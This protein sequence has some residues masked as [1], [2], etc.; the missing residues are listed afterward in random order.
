MNLE[1]PR[2]NHR[3]RRAERALVVAAIAGAL[4]F[5][6]AGIVSTNHKPASLVATQPSSP[7]TAPPST[8][9]TVPAVTT[10]TVPATTTTAPPAL[11]GRD[12]LIAI[13]VRPGDLGGMWVDDGPQSSSIDLDTPPAQ[14]G[15]YLG[16]YNSRLDATVR[17][18]I[19]AP[20]NGYEQGGM[21]STVIDSPSAAAVAGELT[22][23]RTSGF[24]PCAEATAEAWLNNHVDQV[25][26]RSASAQLVTLI[27]APNVVTWRALIN[28]AGS[29]VPAQFGMDIS[30]I[31]S[32]PLLA[33]VRVA[34][35][36]CLS[37]TV[38]GGP[39]L[40]NE[41]MALSAVRDRIA[42]PAS[43]LPALAPDVAATLETNSTG[44][45]Q[46]LTTDQVS[47]VIGYASQPQS[48]TTGDGSSECTW[49]GGT[50]SIVI[51]TGDT[52]AQFLTRMRDVPQPYPG[53]GDQAGVDPKFA[54][55][56]V[57]RRGTIWIEVFV[58]NTAD[59]RTDALKVAREVLPEF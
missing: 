8:T 19:Y 4:G 38:P 54:G 37:A 24:A 52:A 35:C 46:L 1:T 9:T 40:P 27:S 20:R 49:L 29:G 2:S 34:R 36:G 41:T 58:E 16:V 43:Q 39:I 50:E 14:C 51:Q 5:A 33:K 44:P 26:V 17:E 47:A 18:F 22:A 48:T 42:R 53:L 23:V 55:K 30:Y 6:V 57:T 25:S 3:P 31:G 7:A 12:L 13:G 15:P 10:T 32:G 28:Y 21:A 11:S 56:V 45:C 59:P